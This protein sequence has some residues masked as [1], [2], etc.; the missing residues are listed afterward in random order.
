M[1]KIT[2]I[3]NWTYKSKNIIAKFRKLYMDLESANRGILESAA[4]KN[5][6]AG[7]LIKESEALTTLAQAN[8]KFMGSLNEFLN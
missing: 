1:M 7:K 8:N 5:K 4:G 6:A 3:E 2:E